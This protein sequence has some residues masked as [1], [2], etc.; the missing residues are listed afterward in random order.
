MT[1]IA[2]PL[3]AL[4]VSTTASADPVAEKLLALQDVHG[5]I[6]VAPLTPRAEARVEQAEEAEPELQLERALV[7]GQR[8]VGVPE[9]VACA[10]VVYPPALG[11][12][13]L[14]G[15]GSCWSAFEKLEPSHVPMP[16]RRVRP[17][18][19]A[20]AA[21]AGVVAAALLVAGTASAVHSLNNMTI[22]F[23]SMGN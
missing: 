7:S 15:V 11:K 5:T 17:E 6:A 21:G 13:E 22:D 18:V 20:V 10:V 12:T 14:K 2:L 8:V 3:L 1:R 23:G 19:T 9:G 16:R 4:A